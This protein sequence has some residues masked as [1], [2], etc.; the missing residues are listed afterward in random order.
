MSINPKIYPKQ[1][2]SQPM[3]MTGLARRIFAIVKRVFNKAKSEPE[4]SKSAT[5]LFENT[6]EGT[7]SFGCSANNGG[8]TAATLDGRFPNLFPGE[9]PIDDTSMPEYTDAHGDTYK[10]NPAITSS[11]IFTDYWEEYGSSLPGPYTRP[12]E[13]STAP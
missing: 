13:G 4:L 1:D 3:K 6:P 9:T 8:M 12:G 11:E 10:I 5:M 7:W 2:A